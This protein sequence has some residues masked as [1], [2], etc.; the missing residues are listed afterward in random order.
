MKTLRFLPRFACLAFPLL[1]ALPQAAESGPTIPLPDED[2]MAIETYLGT[3]VVGQAIPAPEIADTNR[4]LAANPSAR[5][6]QF[7]E[8][9]RL[10]DEDTAAV[11]R[12]VRTRVLRLFARRGII[13]PEVAAEMRKWEHGGG[14]SLNAAVRI[15][16]TDRKGLVKT[17]GLQR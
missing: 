16:A 2:R 15:E 6:F 3:G 17:L 13:P 8:A 9:R 5:E 7:H 14:F 4:Y 12:E 10:S 11:Q 1:S